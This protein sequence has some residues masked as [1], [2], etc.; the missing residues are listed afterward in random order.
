MFMAA[1]VFL[2]PPPPVKKERNEKSKTKSH[3]TA[4]V[5]TR[6][7]RKIELIFIQPYR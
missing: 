2:P 3:D 7:E 5:T 6:G 4:A 1:V